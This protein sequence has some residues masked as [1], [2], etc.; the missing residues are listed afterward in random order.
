MNK[1][2]GE[3]VAAFK[4]IDTSYDR[5]TSFWN[6]IDNRIDSIESGLPVEVMDVIK[7][8]FTKTNKTNWD[9]LSDDDRNKQLIWIE[10]EYY[11]KK[12]Y[13]GEEQP[14]INEEE[15]NRPI[16]ARIVPMVAPRFDDIPTQAG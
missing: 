15:Y 4:N 16:G 7:S 2:T 12:S 9:L 6:M 3:K 13:V 14:M 11:L 10:N 1:V 5:E 8:E